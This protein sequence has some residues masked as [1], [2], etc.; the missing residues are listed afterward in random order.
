M[1][2]LEGS[3]LQDWTGMRAGGCNR[4]WLLYACGLVDSWLVWLVSQFQKWAQKAH[5][6]CEDATTMLSALGQQ[7]NMRVVC[8]GCVA[9]GLRVAISTPCQ[10]RGAL[11][12][13]HARYQLSGTQLPAVLVL[14]RRMPMHQSASV[15]G[16]PNQL[17]ALE[18]AAWLAGVW[19]CCV[20][21]C[22]C[23]VVQLVQGLPDQL[24]ALYGLRAYQGGCGVAA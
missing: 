14:K 7:S 17:N 8:V 24:N 1:L 13:V 5:T 16:L 9:D 18:L 21:L 20:S 6:A 22:V 10:G 15:Q 4:A 3:H 2:L 11:A 23:C 19:C 12:A